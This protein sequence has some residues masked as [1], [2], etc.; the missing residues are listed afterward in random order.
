M[1]MHMENSTLAHTIILVLM[2]TK[3]LDAKGMF[4]LGLFL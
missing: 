3:Q 4:S 2:K 1:L